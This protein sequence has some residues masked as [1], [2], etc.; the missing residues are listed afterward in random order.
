MTTAKVTVSDLIHHTGEVFERLENEGR[1]EITRSGRL[2][3][4]LIAPNA[5]EKL[6]DEWAQRGEITTDWRE[7]Q[8][9]MRQWLHRAA[10]RA[11]D[12]TDS[13]GSEAILADR[14]ETAR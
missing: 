6:L 12:P 4:T 9:D 14:R 13:K 11:T 8:R 1:L 2:A 10:E 7:R 5:G 3:G